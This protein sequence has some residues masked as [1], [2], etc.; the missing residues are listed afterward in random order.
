LKA[1]ALAEAAV[2]TRARDWRASLYHNIGWTYFDD[3]DATKALDFWQKALALRE[4]MGD[5]GRIRVAKWT[6]ARGYRAIGRLD[7]AQRIQQA[8]VVEFDALGEPDGYVYEEL[9]EI[10]LARGDGAAARPWA[11]KAHAA[12]KDDADLAGSPRLARLADVGAAESRRRSRESAKAP[13]DL[14]APASGQPASDLGARAPDTFRAARGRRS[15]GA[16]DRQGRQQGDRKALPCRK[17]PCRLRQARRGRTAPLHPVD[18]ALSNKAKNIAKLAAILV[19]EHGGEVPTSREALEALPGVGRK[20]ANV[21][22]NTAFGEPTIAVDTHVFRVAN[23]TGD[24]ARRLRRRSRDRLMKLVPEEFRQHAHHWLILHG[25]LRV[26]RAARPA[27]RS[28]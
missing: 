17:H 3:G 10:A 9:A 2:D 26:P 11:A 18:R 13:R 15:V 4:T 7:D 23:R 21:V 12:L 6:V 8:L 27:A 20:T 5:A 25:P 28:A 16:G 1:L 14:R 19:R 22:L 24:R